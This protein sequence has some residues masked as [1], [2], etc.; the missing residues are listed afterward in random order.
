MALGGA[1]VF[2]VLALGGF[3]WGFCSTTEEARAVAGFPKTV[4]MRTGAEFTK[5]GSVEGIGLP[6][7]V[8]SCT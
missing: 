5:M 6:G 1:C 8:C 4:V 3:K 2:S 7:F